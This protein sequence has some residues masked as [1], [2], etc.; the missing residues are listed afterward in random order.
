MSNSTTA[1]HHSANDSSE[2]HRKDEAAQCTICRVC[3]VRIQVRPD[4]LDVCASRRC[5]IAI[6]GNTPLETQRRITSAMHDELTARSRA[7]AGNT[8]RVLALLPVNLRSMEPVTSAMRDRFVTTLRSRVDRAHAGA[9]ANADRP[10]APN[11]AAHLESVLQSGCGV[12]GG[13]CCTRGG[14]HAFL[15]A[16]D[17]ARTAHAMTNG[18]TGVALEVLYTAHLPATHYEESCVFHGAAGCALP[19]AIR[20][21]TCNRY[22]CGGLATLARTLE[23]S[24]HV[25]AVVGAATWSHIERLAVIDATT[26]PATVESRPLD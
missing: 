26:L 9:D 3:G 10:A 25:A 4:T 5:R 13:A 1:A 17:L 24:N 6:L 14:H 18:D 20:A 23:I 12:C 16:A 2:V 21:D 11:H 8:S 22:L 15:S 7:M 19:R